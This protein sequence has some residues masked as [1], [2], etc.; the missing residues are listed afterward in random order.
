M[1]LVIAVVVFLVFL[2]LSATVVRNDAPAA[3]AG[4]QSEIQVFFSAD[5]F[6]AEGY[7]KNIW[8]ARVIP[9]IEKRAVDFA[10]LRDAVRAD[11]VAAGKK[12]GYRAVAEHNPYNFAVKARIK[13]LSA[14]IES[15]NG[16]AEVDVAPFDGKPDFTMM[17]GPIYKGTTIR[18]LLDFVSFDDF[19]NQVEFAKLAM[20]L[21]FHVRDSVIAKTDILKDGG[22]GKVFDMRG[23]T[24]IEGNIDN[25]VVVPVSLVPV[26]E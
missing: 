26:A 9:Y 18:D 23:A 25:P 10:S 17:I 19:K 2:A 1:R 7:V 14:N 13:I 15:K 8:D 20:Q 24:T 3:P 16:R 22:V 4:A 5:K 12:Y 6:D 11:P 21:N